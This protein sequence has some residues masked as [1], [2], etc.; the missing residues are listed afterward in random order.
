MNR[1]TPGVHRYSVGVAARSAP[2]RWWY[3]LPRISFPPP[4][5]H[6]TQAARSCKRGWLREPQHRRRHHHH[7]HHRLNDRRS[8]RD[9]RNTGVFN[10][11]RAREPWRAS[12]K[13]RARFIFFVLP[14]RSVVFTRLHRGGAAE[15][16]LSRSEG[17]SRTE[18][19]RRQRPIRGSYFYRSNGGPRG[20]ADTVR[21]PSPAGGAGAG[22][23]RR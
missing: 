11:S 1:R 2:C 14:R 23:V 6:V 7:H 3:T 10:V 13:R 21:D 12:A 15:E 16:T 9:R 18:Q 8:G 19:Q 22:A 4:E 5:S 17:R 20:V